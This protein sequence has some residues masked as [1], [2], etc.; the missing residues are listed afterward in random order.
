[1]SVTLRSVLRSSAAARSSRRVSRYWCGASPNVRRNSRLKCAGDSA[2]A[3]GQVRHRERLEVAGVGEVLGPQEVTGGRHHVTSIADHGVA[4]AR[5][6]T[7]STTASVGSPA[8]R[9]SLA[10]RP[11]R[12]HTRSTTSSRAGRSC[13]SSSAASP[14]R[15]AAGTSRSCVTTTTG[16]PPPAPR[17]SRSRRKMKQPCARYLGRNPVPYVIL[18]DA[19]HTVFDAYDVASRALSLGQRPALFVI[20]REGQRPLRLGRHPAVADPDRRAGARRARRP[21]RAPADLR[22]STP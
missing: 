5:M 16:S 6:A 19:E 10:R 1:M 9:F 7:H 13:W 3:S 18:S 15:S 4:L 12:C 8:P 21:C 17:S 14:D 2:A 22:R 20:D 11:G